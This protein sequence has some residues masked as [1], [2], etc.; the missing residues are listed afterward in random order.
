MTLGRFVAALALASGLAALATPAQADDIA[1]DPHAP[2]YDAEG[3]TLPPPSVERR[4]PDAFLIAPSLR[5]AE[6]FIPDRASGAFEIDSMF[7]FGNPIVSG[8][9]GYANVGGAHGFA[10]E[11]AMF[12]WWQAVPIS[13]RRG[14]RVSWLLPDATLTLEGFPSQPAPPSWTLSLTT[15]LGGLRF[16]HCL[17]ATCIELAAEAAAGPVMAELDRVHAGFVAGGRFE[18]GFAFWH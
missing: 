10:L 18:I 6:L 14:W 15:R 1:P 4:S 13:D 2:F 5:A 8:G 9:L 7:D 17:H 3:M 11:L 16:A 12:R